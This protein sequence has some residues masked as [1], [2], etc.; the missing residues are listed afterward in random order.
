M[1][2]VIGVAEVLTGVIFGVK[3]VC[4]GVICLLVV[5]GLDV[6]N[7]DGAG[8]LKFMG[9]VTLGLC[10]VI[11]CF[12]VIDSA[13]ISDLGVFDLSWVIWLNAVGLQLF[14][15]C[16]DN[17]DPAPLFCGTFDWVFP[18]RTAK[19]SRS[20]SNWFNDWSSRRFAF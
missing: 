17:K 10:V 6:V 16:P 11:N 14:A 13:V 15:P 18:N 9:P 7:V 4:W 8:R 19:F 2:V 5:F 1:G 12:L 3:L 20:F